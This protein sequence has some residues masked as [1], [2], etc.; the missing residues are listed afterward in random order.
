M[1]NYPVRL[2]RQ[3][4]TETGFILISSLLLLILLTILGLSMSK[5][6][7]LQE[8]IAGNQREKIRAFES[9]QAALN[10]GEWWLNSVG[11]PVAGTGVN[12]SGALST[13]NVTPM[14]CSNNA[15]QTPT[16][17]TSWMPTATTWTQGVITYSPS[18]MTIAATGGQST[19]YA[20]PMLYIQYLGLSP[21]DG[22][23]LY[24]ITAIGY[25]GNASAI[26]VVQSLFEF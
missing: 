9:A 23:A 7:G 21:T 4:L 18:N 22:N 17:L 26:A 19:Y 10:Y 15:L 3:P 6:F 11:S 16:V 1:M 25:G 14:V 12:C 13:K 2:I 5:S 24:Q 20:L 8:M